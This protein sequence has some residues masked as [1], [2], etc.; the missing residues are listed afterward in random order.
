MGLIIDTAERRRSVFWAEEGFSTLGMVLSLLITLCLVFTAARVYEINS[1]SADVQDVA[2]AAVLAGEN[3]VAEFYIVSQVCDA[4]VLSLNLSRLTVAGLGIVAACIPPTKGLATSLFRAADDISKA[5]SSFSKKAKET[6]DNL[7]RALP[8]LANARALAVLNANSGKEGSM[9]V[10]MVVL[11][12][13]EA[14]DLVELDLSK[15]DDAIDAVEEQSGDLEAVAQEAEEAA[16]RVNEAKRKG[17]QADCGAYPDY[18]LYER[19]EHLSALSGPEN[20]YYASPDAWSFSV[21]LDR[22][23]RYYPLRLQSESATANDP[24][25]Q[26]DSALRKRFYA[27]AVEEVSK[28]YVRETEDSFDCYFPLLPKNTSEMKETPLYTE[29]CYP[30]TQTGDGSRTAH[31]YSGCPGMSEAQVV[32]TVSISQIDSDSSLVTCPFCEFT[33]GSMGKVAAASTSISNGFEHHYRIVA[34]AADEYRKARADF[35]PAAKEVKDIAGGMFEELLAAYEDA[36]NLRITVDPPGKLG[37]IAIVAD[38]SSQSAESFFPS[39]YVRSS[40][41]LGARAA[42]SSATLL[43]DSSEEGRTVINSFL[44]GLDVTYASALAPAQIV[45]DLWSAILDSYGTGQQALSQGIEDA[46]DSIP[47]MS[48]SGL[49]IWARTAFDSLVEGLGLEPAELASRKAVLVNS[50][51]VLS[52]D[53]SSAFSARLLDTKRLFMHAGASG[54]LFG[55]ALSGVEQSALNQVESWGDGIELGTIEFFDGAVSIPLTIALPSSVVDSARGMVEQAIG[56]LESLAAAPRS[57]RQ[58]E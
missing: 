20:P 22:A 49:G 35:D 44:E 5:T 41:T 13:W 54:S 50:A 28:G 53:S 27:Y 32:G 39:S 7:Q 23:K 2:D 58:W 10:G 38:I 26:A 4:V 14:E 33:V 45:L 37:A 51:H 43:E 34:E 3:T 30:L 1:L 21:A 29:V 24:E 12:P 56:R 8:F 52:A 25:S 11:A 47:L 16:Q 17:Y 40:G 6:L 18:C 31:A 55:A 36:A 57:G 19:A 46:L 9:Y 15:G 48:E 42:I